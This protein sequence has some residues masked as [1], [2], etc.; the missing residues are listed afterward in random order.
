MKKRIRLFMLAGLALVV[1]AAVGLAYARNVGAQGNAPNSYNLPQ[2]WEYSSKFVCGLASG[3]GTPPGEPDVTPG[4]YATKVNI[5]NPNAQ[6]VPIMLKVVLANP[7]G[8]TPPGVPPTQRFSDRIRPD[9]AMS[10]N[11]DRIVAL[12]IQNNTPP[13]STFIEGYVVV[14][15]LPAGT[16]TLP[17]LDVDDVYTIAPPNPAGG[18]TSVNGIDVTHVS[19]RVLPAGTWPF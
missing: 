4:I 16:T 14:D 18:P 13:S 12:L 6:P 2:R 17:Q 8:I 7:Q 3:T 19:G 9:W 1:L 10:I 5:H 15:A 11:C